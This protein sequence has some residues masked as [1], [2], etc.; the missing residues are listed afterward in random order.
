MK[1]SATRNEAGFWQIINA[2]KSLG[3]F[4]AWHF[5]HLW[6][7]YK[8]WLTAKWAVFIQ[9]LVIL[10]FVINWAWALAKDLLSTIGDYL[11]KQFDLALPASLLHTFEV[12]NYI[13]PV[14]ETLVF[15]AGYG[16][17]CATMMLYHHIK[18]YVPG[19]VSG[20]T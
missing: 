5:H 7:I 3:D 18:S 11:V 2:L 1:L 10:H 16:I 15:F 8:E 4:L 9:L 6:D 19:A 14:G 13:L 12:A 20:G 17:L